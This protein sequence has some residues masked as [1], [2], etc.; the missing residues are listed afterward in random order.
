M[1]VEEGAMVFLIGSNGAGKTTTLRAISGLES[2]VS[3]EIWFEGER[4]DRATPARIV[5]MGIIHVPEGRRVFPYLSVWENL[6]LGAYLHK[7]H[8]TLN[9]DLGRVYNY[10]PVLKERARQKGG[11]LSGGEQQMLAIARALMGK[12]KLLLMD[13]PS[14]GLAPKVVQD[15]GR[16]ITRINKK[17]GVTVVLVE[18][19]ARLALSI[20][21]KGYVLET[22]NVIFEGESNDLS[23]DERVK[24]AYL[25][26]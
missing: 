19:N 25:G 10:F 15:I 22:G 3:G 20:A 7:G 2:P 14:I 21:D 4:I 8:K 16:I 12:P 26:E 13:E 11:S 1:S 18:Q 17:E 23:K 5:S 6:K 9:E 24:K